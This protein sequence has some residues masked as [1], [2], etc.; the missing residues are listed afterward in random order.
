MWV[1]GSRAQQLI[2]RALLGDCAVRE[3]DHLI[4][5]AHGAHPVG[6]DQYGLILYEPRQ[7]GL[8]Q[9]FIFHIQA[10]GCLIQQNDGGIF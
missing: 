2:R 1:N 3:H 8:D 4:R 5:A 9:R 7:G 10:C 6:D